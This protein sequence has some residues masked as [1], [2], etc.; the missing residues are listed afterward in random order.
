MSFFNGVKLK[1]NIFS[2]VVQSLLIEFLTK[3]RAGQMVSASMLSIPTF[4][5]GHRSE[6]SSEQW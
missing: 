2:I 6:L 3:S 1:I 5:S 4:K